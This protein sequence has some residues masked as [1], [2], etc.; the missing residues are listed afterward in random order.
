VSMEVWAKYPS[1]CGASETTVS[2]FLFS[3]LTA[4]YGL[5]ATE[6]PM[7][8]QA[9][10]DYFGTVTLFDQS[11]CDVPKAYLNYIF[12]DRNFENPSFGFVQVSS[13]AEGSFEKLS[14]QKSIDQEGYL[15]IYTCVV[16]CL[17]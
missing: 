8:Y 2:T 14:L 6:T 11:A 16:S 7:A 17:K 1:T 10:D 9:F 5:S 12:F 15:Y 3:A 4:T 13:N